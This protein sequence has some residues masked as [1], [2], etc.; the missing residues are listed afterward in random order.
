MQYQMQEIDSPDCRSENADFNRAM[1]RDTPRDD[2]RPRRKTQA[3]AVCS[4][5]DEIGED[6]GKF[7][8]RCMTDAKLYLQDV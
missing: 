2:Q 5:E 8:M 1:N 4:T 6:G 3:P 7:A